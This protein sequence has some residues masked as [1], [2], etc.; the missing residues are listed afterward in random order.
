VQVG[1]RQRFGSRVRRSVAPRLVAAAHPATARAGR[2]RPAV[3]AEPTP[4]TSSISTLTAAFRSSL[5]EVARR[6]AAMRA[7][8]RRSHPV[9]RRPAA[10]MQDA[11]QERAPGLGFES[12]PA[13]R[14]A[15]VTPPGSRNIEATTHHCG[16]A[17]A[18]PLAI[19]RQRSGIDER[20]RRT[21]RT[22][23]PRSMGGGWARRRHDSNSASLM[24]QPDA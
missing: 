16:V 19:H 18:G 20:R 1:A 3:S 13:C 11:H 5:R 23:R 9:S 6:V 2:E 14:G 12:R 7:A 10:R 21:R 8:G 15:A 24:R 4:S 17:D 22:L